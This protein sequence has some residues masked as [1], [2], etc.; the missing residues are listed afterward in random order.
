VYELL[1]KVSAILLSKGPGFIG[2]YFFIL[3]TTLPT[4]LEEALSATPPPNP[5]A[6]SKIISS[7]FAY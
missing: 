3:P 1:L 5:P 4:T 6:T 2:V 7:L